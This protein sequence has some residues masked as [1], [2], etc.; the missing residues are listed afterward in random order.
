VRV[1]ARVALNLV[2]GVFLSRTVIGSVRFACVRGGRSVTVGGA[3]DATETI[4]LAA[5]QRLAR[6]SGFQDQVRSDRGVR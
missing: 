6:D 3:Q 4:K 2:T 1:V 5:I